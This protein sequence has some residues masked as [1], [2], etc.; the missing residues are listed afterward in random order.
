MLEKPAPRLLDQLSAQ[1][2]LKGYSRATERNYGYWMRR[3]VHF[4]E[5]QH[6]AQ[7][8]AAAVEEF[9]SHLVRHEQSSASTQNQA[10][11]ALLFLYARVLKTPIQEPVNALRAK[12]PSRVPVVLSEAETACLL[13]QMTGTLRL[14]VELTYGAGLR[15]SETLGLRIQDLDLEQRRVLVR[16]GKGQKDRLSIVPTSLVAKLRSHLLRVKRLHVDDIARGYGSTVLPRSYARRLTTARSEFS[17]QFV[18]PSSSLFH[19]SSTGVHGRWH[20]HQSTF[21]RAIA[22]AA[23][24]A[25]IQKRVTVHTLRHSFATHL[26]HAGVDIRR[27]QM[28]LGHTH[29]NTTM[30]YAHIVDSFQ[31]QVTSP[32]DNLRLPGGGA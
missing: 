1:I 11:A 8:G 13:A 17:W 4:H 25:D 10:L 27:V 20:A 15:L 30:I 16:N 19:D 3:Y 22:Q 9:L 18:F 23:K 5:N 7:L 26:I 28:L 29:V 21:Q 6:P 2:R 32:L 24:Q 31:L 12:K 14:M